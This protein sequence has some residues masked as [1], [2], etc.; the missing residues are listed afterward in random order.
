MEQL[1]EMLIA[2]NKAIPEES[3]YSWSK[4]YTSTPF[5]YYWQVVFSELARLDRSMRILEIGAGQGDVTAIGCYLG[6]KN[7][8]AYERTTRDYSI[9]KEKIDSL[10]GR[11]NVLENANY[12]NAGIV[13]DVLI[14]VNC[15]YADNCVDKEQYISVLKG[16]YESAD[17]PRIFLLEVI[18]PSY[19]IADVDFP[20][21]IR[22]SVEDIHN[23]FPEA[24]IASVETYKYPYNKRSK[25]L[26]I[27]K[28][29]S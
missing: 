2:Y 4:Q 28:H 25:K 16:Y 26:Y 23:M 10:F 3:R 1:Q 22:L 7:I 15:A 12:N 21:W 17:H 24:E 5:P 14:L 29:T 11:T 6:F 18:D 27:I 19:D 13:A 9:A 20:M 8:S